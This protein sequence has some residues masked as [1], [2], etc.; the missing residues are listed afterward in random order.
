MTQ[1]IPDY[2]QEKTLLIPESLYDMDDAYC[3]MAHKDASIFY[4][5]IP[6]SM[7]DI[8]FFTN[9]PCLAFVLSG[10]ETFASFADDEILVEA[11]QMLFMPKNS[12]MISDFVRTA[13]PLEAFLFFFDED[14]IK[15][16]LKNKL[17]AVQDSGRPQAPFKRDADMRVTAFMKALYSV[18]QD[19]Q[20]TPELVRLKLLE[21]L[22]LLDALDE[23]GKLRGFLRTT[24]SQVPKRNI[25]RLLADPSHWRLS[26]ADLAKLSGRSLTSF[27]RDFKRQFET[28]PQKWLINARLEQA[29]ELLRSSSMSVS[30]VALDVGYDNIS[31]FISVFKKKYGQSPK[32]LR[33]ENNW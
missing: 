14:I 23:G 27:N 17:H 16:F 3:V 12:Y 8:D 26:V 10:K 30:E 11:G 1:L 4:K 9:A 18:Y 31:H 2:V 5:N 33:L 6:Q 15:D 21:I 13:G 29:Y 32:K 7:V 28:T 24:L 22:A 20:A 19:V 25:R